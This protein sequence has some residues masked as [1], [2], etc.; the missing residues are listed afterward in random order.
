MRY[1]DLK[2]GACFFLFCI[3]T[4]ANITGMVSG[5]AYL[6]NQVKNNVNL[7]RILLCAVLPFQK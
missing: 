5:T 3:C 1:F 7:Q 6:L 2:I 4:G